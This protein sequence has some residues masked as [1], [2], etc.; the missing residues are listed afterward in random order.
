MYTFKVAIATPVKIAPKRNSG[1]PVSAINRDEKI[2]NTKIQNMP[3]Y[4]QVITGLRACRV[5]VL[6]DAYPPLGFI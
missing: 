6:T 5:D 4:I 2:G 1:T 3:E